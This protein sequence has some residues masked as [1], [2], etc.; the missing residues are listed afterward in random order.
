MSQILLVRHGQASFGSSDYDRLSELGLEQSRV[1]GQ[2]FADSG[3]GFQRV[4]T[5]SLRRHRQTAEA[6]LGISADI[7][8]ETEPGFDEY[9]HHDVLVKHHPPFKD[10]TEVKRFLAS[11]RNARF[12]FQEIFAAA[13]ARWMS[14]GHDGEYVESWPLFRERCVGALKRLLGSLDKSQSVIVFTSGGTIATL[15]QYLLGF[16]DR[17]VAALNWTLVNGAVTKLL[18]RPGHANL[19]YL[20]SYAHLERL[21]RSELITYR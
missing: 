6:C 19:S 3:Q 5:G 13:M 10:P 9:N 16:S 14:G 2:W 20:N 21:G 12:E 4:V 8:W 11:S 18:C 17:Q 15:C 1:L 7:A